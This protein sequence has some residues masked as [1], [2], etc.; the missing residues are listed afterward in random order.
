MGYF[1]SPNVQKN[2]Q[3]F[4]KL[5]IIWNNPSK[6]DGQDPALTYSEFAKG[7]IQNAVNNVIELGPAS[8]LYYTLSHPENVRDVTERAQ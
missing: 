1:S 3:N 7:L 4:I 6:K 5:F 2:I 8:R